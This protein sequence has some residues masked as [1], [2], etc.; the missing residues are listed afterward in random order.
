MAAAKQCRFELIKRPP[1]SPDL[2]SSENDLI[3]MK[4][5]DLSGHHLHRDDDRHCCG[6]PSFHDGWTTFVNVGG[7]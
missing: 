3:P 1:C 5:K 7:D 2:A 6:P 4:K